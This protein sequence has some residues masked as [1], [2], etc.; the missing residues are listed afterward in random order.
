GM[1]TLKFDTSYCVFPNIINVTGGIYAIAYTGSSDDGYLK[2]VNI[3]NNGT[4]TGG[5]IDSL[6]FDASHGYRPDIIHI[7]GRVY[8]IVHSGSGWDGYVKTLRIGENG[9]IA[10]SPD[11]DY[12][13]DSSNSYDC[14][15]IHI[16]GN[17]FA[18]A[19]RNWYTDGRMRTVEIK[20]TPSVGYIVA[21][22]NCYRIN[23][24]S[25]TVFAY[26]NGVSLTAP[27]SP[28]FNYVVLT[29]DKN[30]GTDQMKLYVNT[31]L[32][33]KTTY[34]STINTNNN[35]LYFGWLN[36][37]VDEITLW[38]TAITQAEINQHYTDLT[39]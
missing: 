36:S 2:T 8:A 19:Y 11:G 38:R 34:S 29:Y 20:Y 30:A 22:S 33:S 35:N 14:K 4:I 39:S 10:N 24:N 31:T 16:N 9:N 6:E 1:D 7:K 5:V 27:I 26:I 28:G 18:I 17:V 3:S 15:I 12:E 25:T 37:M 32:V 23:A 13:F 21:R